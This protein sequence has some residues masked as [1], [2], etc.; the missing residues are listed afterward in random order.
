[1]HAD[2]KEAIVQA[3]E[4]INKLSL[5]IGSQGNISMRFVDSKGGECVAITPS[6]ITY[7]VLKRD[8]I[9]ILNLEGKV[10][11]GGHR[12]SIETSLHLSIYKKRS[13]VNA[14]VHTHSV[15]ASVLAVCG[16]EIPAV[17][18]DQVYYLGKGVKLAGR[19]MSG[20][21]KLDRNV[22]S[23]LDGNN[24]VLM[25]NHGALAVGKS[26]KEALFNAQMLE[27]VAM[28]YVNTKLMNGVNTLS[29]SACKKM[30]K[31]YNQTI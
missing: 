31:L 12:P 17:L 30:R 26:M 1:M 2:I 3:A 10:Q 13:D 29:D 4:K 9:V 28:I 8:D 19:A 25:Q 11:E 16:M 15:Y 5:V 21:K 20:S 7:D 6:G 27:K 22:I 18:Y 23:A 14:V 24:A